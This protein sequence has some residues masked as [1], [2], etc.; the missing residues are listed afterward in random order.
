MKYLIAIVTLTLMAFLAPAVSAEE[1]CTNYGPQSPRDIDSPQ[2]TNTVNFSF[3]P[4]YDQ[5]NLCD[6]HFHRFAEHKA[7]AYSTQ[8]GDQGY[9][10]STQDIA[11][12]ALETPSGSLCEG[13]E[14]GD[15]VEVHWVYT[16]CDVKPGP[17]LPSCIPANCTN[18][19]LRVEA[20][21]F[22]LV[23]DD[24]AADFQ[25]FDLDTRGPLEEYY[26]AR[27]LPNTTGNP[28]T[29]LGST[30]GDKFSHEKCSTL[31]VSWS[32]RPQCANLN[33]S[34]LGRW[35]DTNIFNEKKAQNVRQLVT[36]PELLSHIGAH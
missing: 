3:A 5:L 14:A 34:S 30:T 8:D 31:Q 1:L 20:Q 29:Y 7:A 23:N 11:P 35:C 33:I 18:P 28:V 27:A 2:G 10:C 22:A 17:G 12:A 21:V 19:N 13:L 6:I 25:R 4:D 32:V 15:T 9:R 26:Q 16:S 36:A 24:S